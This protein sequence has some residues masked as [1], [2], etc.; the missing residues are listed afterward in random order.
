MTDR[1]YIIGAGAIGKALAVFLKLEGRNVTLLRG[2]VDGTMDYRELIEVILPDGTAAQTM[3]DVTTPER[4]TSFDG[5]VVLANKSFGNERLAALLEPKIRDVPVVLMQNGLGIEQPFINR[6]FPLIFRCVLFATSQSISRERLQF[7]AVTASPVGVVRGVV[8]NLSCIIQQLNNR[9]FEFRPEQDI[10]PLVWKKTIINSVFNTV[11]PL[12]E[13]DN[14]IFYRNKKVVEMAREVVDECIKVAA[15]DGIRLD[16]EDVMDGLLQISRCS[17]GMLISTYQDLRRQQP[18][19]I[20]ALNLAI[21]RAADR[22]PGSGR[23]PATRLL[24][25]LIQ[26]KSELQR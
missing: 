10:R 24:G 23:V 16:A 21:V 15:F 1:I 14:G 20:D 5:L 25:T 9:Y 3:V 13:T 8:A 4:V 6:H 2:S 12:L 18:T 19:E 26:L 17:E 22:L 11:C 7:R